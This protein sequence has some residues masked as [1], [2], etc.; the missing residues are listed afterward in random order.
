[1]KKYLLYITTLIASFMV[2][3]CL[4]D[5]YLDGCPEETSVPVQLTISFAGNE[6]MS[7][8]V[9]SSNETLDYT[10][11][12]QS[13]MDDVYV[14][15]FDSNTDKLLYLVEDLSVGKAIG[16]Y[17]TRVLSGVMQSTTGNNKVKLAVLANL[18][19]QNIEFTGYDNMQAFLEAQINKTSSDIYKTL[20]YS[21]SKWDIS[22]RAIPMWG[23][24]AETTVPSNGVELDCS[25]YRAVAKVQVWVNDKQGIDGV[26][27]TSITL[28]NINESGYCVSW[29]QTPSLDEAIQY[30][31]ITVPTGLSA[32]TSISYTDLNVIDAFSDQIYLPEQLN[33]ADEEDK[34]GNVITSGKSVE[35]VLNYT[36]NDEVQTPK[37]YKFINYQNFDKIIRNHSYIFNLK[38]QDNGFNMELLVQDWDDVNVT[39]PFSSIISY[40][41][42]GWIRKADDYLDLAGNEYYITKNGNAEF[43]FRID[44]PLNCTYTV[45]LTDNINFSYSKNTYTD[46]NSTIWQKIIITPVNN[47]TQKYATTMKVFAI[48]SDNGKSVELDV[49]KTG[50]VETSSGDINHYIIKQEWTD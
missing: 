29:N 17:Y 14:L 10:T 9:S 8:D 27:I 46:E 20:I 49:T 4:E 6:P 33:T 28:N 5:P 1:M 25:L 40:T 30:S 12:P 2:A 15:V 45:E 22:S 50:E 31:N 23:V 39:V 36:L 44:N 35:L 41:V 47:D 13:R 38:P 43:L 3:S 11:E 21:Y 16:S 42:N 18:N 7:R 19:N 48:R 34:D 24:T 32:T 26:K 37:T